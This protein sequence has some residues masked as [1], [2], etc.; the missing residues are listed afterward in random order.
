MLTI[1]MSYSV[2]VMTECGWQKRRRRS[3]EAKEKRR[4]DAGSTQLVRT[5]LIANKL[6][7]V[8]LLL[9][10][11]SPFSLAFITSALPLLLLIV[12]LT[13]LFFPFSASDRVFDPSCLLIWPFLALR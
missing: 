6:F 4:I 9:L 1:W 8:I 3:E 13:S 10:L 11:P 7:A 2:Y 12:C 5:Q